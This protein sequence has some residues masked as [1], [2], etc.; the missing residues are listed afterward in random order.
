M[1]GLLIDKLWSCLFAMKF[2]QK[3]LWMVH[4]LTCKGLSEVDFG[5][6]SLFNFQAL[7]WL[8]RSV[9]QPTCLHDLLW[10]FVAALTPTSP[11]LQP[12]ADDH[13]P[14]DQP[15]HKDKSHD[16][17]RLSFHSTFFLC[18]EICNVFSIGGDIS[19]MS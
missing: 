14:Q 5:Q 15:H 12:P 7:N 17:V 3:I 9:T 6:C 13:N 19:L 4:M 11:P 18:T 16:L 8:L 10:C 2:T 1:S